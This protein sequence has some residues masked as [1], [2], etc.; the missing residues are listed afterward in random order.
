MSKEPIYIFDIDPLLYERLTAKF[1]KAMVTQMSE[2]MV[3]P[4]E[5]TIAAM[6]AQKVAVT[7]V[8]MM[9]ELGSKESEGLVI[10]LNTL[11]THWR[12][13]L[14]QEFNAEIDHHGRIIIREQ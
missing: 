12:G 11:E 5:L 4:E 8:K 3:S 9:H 13:L 10:L 2:G 6:A 1:A 7:M 14:A